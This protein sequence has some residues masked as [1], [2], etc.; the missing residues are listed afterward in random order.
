MAR[1]M[2][3]F[4]DNDGDDATY[5]DGGLETDR[6][7]NRALEP[8]HYANDQRPNNH[9]TIFT[10][11]PPPQIPT[12]ILHPTSNPASFNNVQP[13][14]VPMD[15][16]LSNGMQRVRSREASS[17]EQNHIMPNPEPVT[18]PNACQNRQTPQEARL[19]AARLMQQAANLMQ[20]AARMNAEA[21]RLT[22]YAADS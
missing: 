1:D 17:L 5:A 16:I 8:M 22:A 21:A 7:G 6:Q 12:Q 19:E 14:E 4:A 15:P 13:T 18:G 9:N 20:E 3:S 11:A 10:Q 2:S